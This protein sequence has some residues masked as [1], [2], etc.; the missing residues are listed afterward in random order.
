[1]ANSDKHMKC[2]YCKRVSQPEYHNTLFPYCGNCHHDADGVSIHTCD[3]CG[4]SE[5]SNRM[6]TERTCSNCW[7]AL[8]VA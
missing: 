8:M 3:L 6:E 7:Q 4:L 5:P 1:M 2:N